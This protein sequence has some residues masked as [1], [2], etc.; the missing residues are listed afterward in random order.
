[1]RSASRSFSEWSQWGETTHT[2]ISRTPGLEG[3]RARARQRD[4]VITNQVNLICKDFHHDHLIAVFNRRSVPWPGYTDGCG[5]RGADRHAYQCRAHGRWHRCGRD[6]RRRPSRDDGVSRGVADPEPAAPDIMDTTPKNQGEDRSLRLTSADHLN[7]ILEKAGVLGDLHVQDVSIISDRPTLMSRIIRL[8]LTYDGPAN[9]LPGSL[10]VKTGRPE[11]QGNEWSGGNKEVVFY[12]DVAPSLPAGLVPRCF[13]AHRCR[14][15][16]PLAS[17]S[18][19]PDRHPR[20]ANGM[21]AAS[22]GSTVPDDHGITRAFPCGLVGRPAAGRHDRSTA[23]RCSHGPAH[24]AGWSDISRCLQT[25][26]AT[27]SQAS[28]ARSTKG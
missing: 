26:L 24:P 7:A 16:D 15:H 9:A 5:E 22:V 23:R 12:R 11:R 17:R 18:R 3:H 1:M 28:G 20:P 19:R 8:R 27:N 25:A 14:R 4:K 10:I 2:N 21:A 13:E 6:R